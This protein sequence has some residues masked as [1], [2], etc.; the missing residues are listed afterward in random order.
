MATTSSSR[1]ARA[2]N[3]DSGEQLLCEIGLDDG[4]RV[5]VAGSFAQI[6]SSIS[7]ARLEDATVTLALPDR[8]PPL[9]LRAR[10]ILGVHEMTRP[11]WRPRLVADAGDREPSQNRAEPPSSQ[12]VVDALGRLGGSASP[13]ELAL[14]I[15]CERASL[16]APLEALRA[17]GMVA[18]SGA[19]RSTRYHLNSAAAATEQATPAPGA[20]PDRKGVTVLERP[21][22]A[23]L[24]RGEPQACAQAGEARAQLLR[25]TLAG[26]GVS[27]SVVAEQHGP[28]VT[29]LELELAAGTKVRRVAALSAE[30][31]YALACER[32]RVIAPIPGRQA[33]GVELA[34][35]QRRDVRLGDLLAN[36]PAGGAPALRVWLG[37]T[38]DG[39]AV[40]ADL[41]QMPHLLVAGTTG[42]GKSVALNAILCSILVCAPPQLVR[43][44]L[45]D[46]KQ[47]EFAPYTGIAHLFAPVVT[48]AETATSVLE[49]LIGEMEARYAT[50]SQAQVRDIAALNQAREGTGEQPLP[51]LLCVVDEFADLMSVAAQDVEETIVRLAQKARAVG[52]HLVLA[53]QSPRVEVITGLIK[54]NMPSRL[55][56]TVASMVDSRVILDRNGA[57]ALLGKGDMLF[58]PTGCA[59]PTRVQGALV[60]TQEVS[61]ITDRLRGEEPP[62]PREDPSASLTPPPPAPS[63]APAK[64]R[65]RHRPP[66]GERPSAEAA[67]VAP[68]GPGP[69]PAAE[70][71][72]DVALGL[73]E[74]ALVALEGTSMPQA[75]ARLRQDDATA[76]STAALDVVRARYVLVL[77]ERIEAG[78][79]DAA[80]LDRFERL[81]GLEPKP[82]PALQTARQEEAPDDSDPQ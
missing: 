33:V 55:A 16:R 8:S 11:A 54:A 5:I 28:Q 57:E 47:V 42:A 22:V 51:Y 27:A 71:A 12:R 81:A 1:R 3:V 31:A 77:L 17:N 41:A 13:A 46:T 50:L 15:G 24:D 82:P 6:S 2:R 53:T 72:R 62:Q 29:R 30:I 74:R 69:M 68:D 48:D 9:Q 79:S 37:E 26:F 44:I 32:V 66:G 70:G 61:R 56:L 7:A 45:I 52:I 20:T 43:L 14:E 18:R 19:T 21:L 34:N 25:D 75:L 60:T 49:N 39:Q 38:L 36:A 63:A 23:L 80:L 4:E 58:A 10:R 59:T 76:D 35:A 65:R 78:D 67:P 40:S 64:R 73:T